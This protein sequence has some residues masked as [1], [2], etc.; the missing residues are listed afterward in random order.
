MIGLN[1]G[2]NKAKRSNI[3]RKNV[4][5]KTIINN[6]SKNKYSGLNKKEEFIIEEYV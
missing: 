1:F 4:T 6:K 3:L 2:I 5:K